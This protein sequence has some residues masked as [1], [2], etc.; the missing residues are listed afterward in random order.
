MSE[1]IHP[2]TSIGAVALTVADLGRSLA[3]YQE[4]IGLRL[5]RQEEQTAYLG[6]GGPDLL[7]LTERPGARAVRGTTGLYHFA[8]LT[9]SR[10]ALAKSLRRLA[11]TGTRIGGFADHAVS[12]AIYLSDP[13]GNGI[14][15]YRDRP[16]EEWPYRNGELQMT[17]VALDV[18]G[19]LAELEGKPWSWNGLHPDTTIGHIHLHVGNLEEAEAFYTQVLGFDLVTRYGPSA[20]F[21]SAGDYHHHIGF[22]TWAGVG[23]PPPPDDAAGLRWY[24]IRLPSAA[25]RDRVVARVREAGLAVGERPDGFMVRD[26]AENGILLTS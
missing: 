11:E 17:T 21:V 4:V 14:E 24:E 16:R 1:S 12:E 2:D 26:P 19:V 18:E 5:H 25:E 20:A 22:N 7:I 8:I 23:V 13:D 9:P 15:I 6:V 10:L 3:Y